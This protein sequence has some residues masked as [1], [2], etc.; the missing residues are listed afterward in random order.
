[1]R[2]LV[3]FGFRRRLFWL[4]LPVVLLGSAAVAHAQADPNA[5]C[6]AC[7]GVPGREALLASGE[8]LP[9]YVDG[10]AYRL[11][12]HGQNQLPCTACHTRI[13]GFPHEPLLAFD[14]RDYQLDHYVVCRNCHPEVYNATLDSMHARALAAGHREAAIC[15]DCH[16]AH[17]ITS[18]HTPRQKISL[19]CS[20]CHAFIFEQYKESVHG[21]ALLEE[22]NPDVPT[23]VDCHGVHNIG[24]PT[25]AAFRLRSPEICGECHRNEALMRKYGISTAVFNTYV[26]DFHGTTVTLFE[27][28]H[29][30]QPTNKAVCFDCHGIHNIKAVDDPEATV[31]KENLLQTCRKCHPDADVN[32]PA[33]WTSHYIPDRERY[34]LVYYVNLFYQIIIPGTIG[35]MLS[36]VMLDAFRRLLLRMRRRRVVKVV[37]AEVGHHE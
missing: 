7:H 30:D 31:V 32:F 37:Q 22:S 9:L 23:C 3:V 6:L 12:V 17:D 16:G 33:S 21:A 19:T 2:L 35:F 14:R 5:A 24:D 36:F 29:P 28:Q 26:A 11:S 27:R 10:E 34:P 1:M 4:L 20:K 15:T 13:M 18:P 25:T 8:R